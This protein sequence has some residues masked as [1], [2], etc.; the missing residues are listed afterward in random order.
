MERISYCSEAKISWQSTI[1]SFDIIPC[2]VLFKSEPSTVCN[3]KPVHAVLQAR[4]ANVKMIFTIF[5]KSPLDR[6][7]TSLGHMK[8]YKVV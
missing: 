5:L 3:R 1:G 2:G 6:V 8:E 4:V 7:S